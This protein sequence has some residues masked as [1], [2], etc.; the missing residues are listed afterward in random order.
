[1]HLHFEMD[2]EGHKYRYATHHNDKDDAKEDI[3]LN[4]SLVFKCIRYLLEM[5]G[6]LF[7]INSKHLN[8]PKKGQNII[9]ISIITLQGNKIKL[10]EV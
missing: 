4:A 6:C 8:D 5:P 10:Q 3:I 7:K 1:M 2:G 9:N